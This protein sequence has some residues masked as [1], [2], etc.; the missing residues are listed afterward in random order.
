[1]AVA[2]VTAVAV[3]GAAIG[4]AGAA[5]T[6]S[7]AVKA[8]LNMRIITVP[9]YAGLFRDAHLGKGTVREK[10]D[11]GAGT[12]TGTIYLPA[13]TIRYKQTIVV[14]PTQNDGKGRFTGGTGRYA[15]ATGSFTSLGHHNGEEEREDTV[16]TGTLR[17]PR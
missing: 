6:R 10:R 7:I 14:A 17:L 13:G 12:G 8:S 5:R 15:G 3:A 11:R 2:G 4:T 1:M 16:I 9:T